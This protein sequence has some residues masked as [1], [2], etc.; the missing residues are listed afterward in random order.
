MGAASE[1]LGGMWQ[2]AAY[3]WWNRAWLK[4]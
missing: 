4:K 1:N 3:Q 2:A